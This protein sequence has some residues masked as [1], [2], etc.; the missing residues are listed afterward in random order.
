MS[1][2]QFTITSPLFTANEKQQV[3]QLLK[4]FEPQQLQ[5]LAG[6]L[7]GLNQANKQLL[8]LLNQFPNVQETI[9][10]AEVANVSATP[11]TVLFGS[12]SGN[13]KSVAKSLHEKLVAKGLSV[14]LQD[15]NQYNATKLK[16]EKYLLVIVSTHGEGD[17]PPAAEDLHAFIHNRK[18]PK[19][20][21]AKFA[22][23]ALG[24]QSYVNYCQTGKDFDKRLAELGG[25]RIADRVDADVDF[26][27]T[28]EQWIENV[29]TKLLAQLN[30]TNGVS[31]AA[32]SSVATAA[33][34]AVKKVVYNRK[35]PFAATVLEKVQLNGRGSQKKTYHLELSLEGSGL[36]YL[37]GDTLGIFAK[38]NAVLV[39]EVLAQTKWDGASTLVYK[40]HLLSLEEILTQH[41][42]L[43]T[44]SGVLLEKLLHYAEQKKNEK[45]IAALKVILDNKKELVAF[46]YGKDVLDIILDYAH[47]ISAEEFINLALPLQARLYSIASSIK[48][49]EEE[50]HLTIGQVLFET[51]GRARKGVCSNH[52]AE[53]LNVGD[54]VDV[55]IEKN[56]SFRLPENENTPVIMVGPGTGIAPFRAFVEERAATG[57][58]GK[59]W[60]FF[61]DRNFT[62]DFLYQLEWQRHLKSG[63]LT[64]M[65]TAF[66]RDTDKKVYVQH[67]LQQNAVEVY[68]WLQ[69]GAHFYICGDA[70]QMARDVRSALIDI[71][72]KQAAISHE[73]AVHF[74]KELI[75]AGRLQEDVY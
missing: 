47:G 23:L 60:L 57:A 69:D 9:A 18:A 52:I 48:E 67:R 11:V 27:E 26:E 75:K 37:P 17:P 41:I 35:N 66:S 20:G 21:G 64:H 14:S 44:V 1:N 54:S 8:E 16:D 70:K 40:D 24:D 63:A 68:K 55:F 42:E 45:D 34:P 39:S 25:D 22:V 43:T 5:W 74:V 58:K 49:H 56:E 71:V 46:L 3:Q 32:K 6:Y 38:N 2:E 59:N 61:G 12:K 7:T 31:V 29:T 50:V 65:N 53:L 15:M 33:A 30:H 51:C 73:E 4:T 28:A 13:S 19:L 62:T 72:E 10:P 36:T